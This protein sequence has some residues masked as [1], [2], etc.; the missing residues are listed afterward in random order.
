M[1]NDNTINPFGKHKHLLPRFIQ[2]ARDR[3]TT[4]VKAAVEDGWVIKPTYPG[5]EPMETSASLEKGEWRA[6]AINRKEHI[7]LHV[8]RGNGL[9]AI[10]NVPEVY[11]MKELEE[12]GKTCHFCGKTPDRLH[13]VGFTSM[14]CSDCLPKAKTDLEFPG[15]AD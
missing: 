15:W 13:H 8:W 4:W 10:Q 5:H 14:A 1:S 9:V 11:S 2:E 6:H 7:S 12:Q 3:V